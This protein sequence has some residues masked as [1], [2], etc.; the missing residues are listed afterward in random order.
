Y[1]LMPYLP[2]GLLLADRYVASGRLAWL[3]SLALLW[4]VQLSLGHFQIQMWT[5]GLVLLAGGWRAFFCGLPRCPGPFVGLFLGLAWGAAIGWVQL[6]LTRELTGVA[7]FDRP[8]KF[9]SN[10][11]F[12]P[13]HWAQFALPEVF[14]GRSSGAGDAYWGH[15]G[16]TSGEACA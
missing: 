9:L 6:R 11:L 13:A 5:G 16:T 7:G 1:H 15:H 4:G 10:F 8:E 14:L 3:A 12:P 2:L